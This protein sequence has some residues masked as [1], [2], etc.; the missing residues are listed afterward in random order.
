[1]IMNLT[2][3]GRTVAYDEDALTLMESF[4]LKRLTGLTAPEL[5]AGFRQ[6]D[7]ECWRFAWYVANQR[8]GED[9]GPYRDIDFRWADLGAEL[10]LPEPVEV[11]PEEE[12]A[13]PTSP[14]QEPGN[15]T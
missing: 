9:V 1:M 3:D 7:P 8:A 2:L 13:V 12:G 5:A 15:P 14:G 10:V 4:D 11:A 6:Q